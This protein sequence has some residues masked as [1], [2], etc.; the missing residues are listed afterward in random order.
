MVIKNN[1]PYS[2]N[3]SNYK[4]VLDLLKNDLTSQEDEI[5]ERVDGSGW[6]LY[7]YLYFAIDIFKIRPIRAS[8]YIPTPEKI[9]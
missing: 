9:C 2:L 5:G 6:A 8:S 3:K 7:R 4:K 1:T